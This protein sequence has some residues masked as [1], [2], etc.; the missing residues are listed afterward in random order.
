MKP[1]LLKDQ[2]VEELA[3]RYASINRMGGDVTDSIF[4][5]SARIF[6]E[7]IKRNGYTRAEE[8]IKK[9]RETLD[10]LDT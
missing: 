6:K 2:P 5:E 7:L 8:A 4:M 9:A 1:V 10:L 3:I